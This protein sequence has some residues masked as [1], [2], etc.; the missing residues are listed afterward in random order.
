M[1]MQIQLIIVDNYCPTI[2]SLCVCVRVRMCVCDFLSL[3]LSLSLSLY[4]FAYVSDGYI[5][6]NRTTKYKQMS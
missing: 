5:R 1:C 6:K 4:L 3:S 2:F